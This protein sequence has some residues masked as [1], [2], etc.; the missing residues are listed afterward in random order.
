MSVIHPLLMIHT[1]TST[2]Y[3][4]NT[5]TLGSSGLNWSPPKALTLL[6]IPPVPRAMIYNDIQKTVV[7]ALVAGT[8]LP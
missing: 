6:L 1:T 5:L 4:T 2:P 3:T 7:C 8:S